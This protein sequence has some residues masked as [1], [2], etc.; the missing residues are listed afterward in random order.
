MGYV[1][2]G[3]R[4]A[5]HNSATDANVVTE[6]PVPRWGGGVAPLYSPD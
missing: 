5:M 6:A 2:W 4:L 1:E 3:T